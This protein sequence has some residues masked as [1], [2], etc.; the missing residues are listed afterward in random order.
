MRLD[1]ER[2]DM[3]LKGDSF[4]LSFHTQKA[5]ETVSTLELTNEIVISK[6]TQN[7]HYQSSL[8]FFQYNPMP[9]NRSTTLDSSSHNQYGTK[10]KY[11]TNQKREK[12][13]TKTMGLNLQNK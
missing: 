13:K 1:F 11:K 8:F 7:L 12:N 5:R 10:N 9:L 4:G 6:N 3:I 2:R